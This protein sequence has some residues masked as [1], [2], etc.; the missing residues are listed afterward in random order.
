[1]P[2]D[3]RLRVGWLT[4][5]QEIKGTVDFVADIHLAD[6][7]SRAGRLVHEI[8]TID[9]VDFVDGVRDQQRRPSDDGRS[10][11]GVRTG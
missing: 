1:M 9:V 8:L 10:I 2:A 11:R 7:G 3:G 6:G 4:D 5:L